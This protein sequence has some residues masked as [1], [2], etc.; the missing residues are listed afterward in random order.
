[1]LIA[2]SPLDRA[3]KAI[4]IPDAW[5]RLGLLRIPKKSCCVPWRDDKHPSLSIFDDGRRFMDHGTGEGGNVVT[6]VSIFH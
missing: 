4:T 6:F 3:I 5:H 2:E 1:M